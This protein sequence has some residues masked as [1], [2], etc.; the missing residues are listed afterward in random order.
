[1]LQALDEG[2]EVLGGCPYMDVSNANQQ[3]KRLFEIASERNVDIDMHLDFDLDTSWMSLT[4]L[5]R[6]TRQYN[7]HGRVTA[8]HVT[9]LS[10][11][12]PDKLQ[13]T[14]QMIAESGVNITVLPSTDLFL[15]GRAFTHAI[16]RG[17][18]PLMPLAAAGVKCSLS[19]NNIGN[20]FTP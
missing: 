4:E 12:S 19:S 15:S 2:A 20:A 7:Y 6:L 13:E 16:P 1:L 9:K 3:M 11:L 5:C 17:V 10:M 14:A 18:T 8:G